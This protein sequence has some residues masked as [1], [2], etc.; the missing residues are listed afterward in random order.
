M[1]NSLQVVDVAALAVA[2]FL[3]TKILSKKQHEGT[4][5]PGPRPFPIV[6]NLFDVPSVMPWITFAE[7]GK[8]WGTNCDF[9][10][11]VDR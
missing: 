3:F 10:D 9:L 2:F 8:R 6:G 1:L 5:P 11:C 7:W 4:R